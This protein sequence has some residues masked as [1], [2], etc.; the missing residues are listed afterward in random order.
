MSVSVTV[1]NRDVHQHFDGLLLQPGKRITRALAVIC[2]V[3]HVIYDME[4][5]MGP[6][7]FISVTHNNNP[8]P[9]VFGIFIFNEIFLHNIDS[10][11]GTSEQQC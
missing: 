1:K 11:C 4:M 10:H 3:E 2:N 8:G 7:T 6:L 9:G 5:E